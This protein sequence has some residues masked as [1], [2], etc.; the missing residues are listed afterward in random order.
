MKKRVLV[1][2]LSGDFYG[3]KK[4][5][6]VY[7][8]LARTP[9][10][11]STPR[12]NTQVIDDGELRDITPEEYYNYV[13]YSG[14]DIKQ[15]LINNIPNWKGS[16]ISNEQLRKYIDKITEDAR[17][18][19]IHKLDLRRKSEGSSSTPQLRLRCELQN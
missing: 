10:L 9:P 5:D 18:R 6:P 1:N 4:D 12:K 11:V 13:L 7:G 19:A 2:A 17:L 16:E 14:Q 15:Q 8:F 3:T